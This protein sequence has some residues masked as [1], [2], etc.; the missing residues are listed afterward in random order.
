MPGPTPEDLLSRVASADRD[1]FPALLDFRGAA[2]RLVGAFEGP[3]P[4][5]EVLTARLGPVL[6]ARLGRPLRFED[7]EAAL[8]R[9]GLREIRAEDLYDGR[10]QAGVVPTRPGSWHDLVN[11]LVWA[12]FPRAKDALHRRQHEAMEARVPGAVTRLPQARTREQDTLAMVDEGGALLVADRLAVPG[13][14][15][16]LRDGDPSRLSVLVGEGHLR[17]LLF[18]HALLEHVVKG[19]P[20]PRALPVVVPLHGLPPSREGALTAAD[21][22]L[23]VLL[24][25]R[26]SFAA[27]TGIKALTLSEELFRPR[28]GPAADV[29]DGDAAREHQT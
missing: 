22:A 6:E 3:W 8:R 7:Q 21:D 5:A 29:V 20:P 23:A 19:A 2:A 14:E 4:R 16:A 24:Q 27:P 11:A 9:R 13:V 26:T 10:I 17:V 12:T 15:D 25:D 1:L 28:R 18:G